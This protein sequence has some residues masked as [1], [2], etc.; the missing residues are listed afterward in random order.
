ME[1]IIFP[2]LLFYFYPFIFHKYCCNKFMK[3]AMKEYIHTYNRNGCSNVYIILYTKLRKRATWFRQH[4]RF[5]FLFLF[6]NNIHTY[7]YIFFKKVLLPTLGDWSVW[8]LFD[9]FCMVIIVEIIVITGFDIPTFEGWRWSA[10]SN[11][12]LF[13]SLVV[14][15][16]GRVLSWA[17]FSRLLQLWR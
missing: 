17:M 14:V 2:I 8:L 9:Q 3:I 15:A 6:Q 16:K 13:R 4:F 12:P 1:H 11:P 7:I 5:T 10:L